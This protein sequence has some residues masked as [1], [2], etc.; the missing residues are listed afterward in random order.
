MQS[1]REI[2]KTAFTCYS[3][4][5]ISTTVMNLYVQR[6]TSSLIIKYS[7]PIYF[8]FIKCFIN[9]RNIDYGLK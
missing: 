7:L 3:T 8:I 4:W 2:L 9:I 6:L 1:T 5:C